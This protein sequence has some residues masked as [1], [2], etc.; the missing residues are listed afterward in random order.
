MK[1]LLRLL[2]FLLL[3]TFCGALVSACSGG[4]TAPTVPTS[5][6][7]TLQL[8]WVTQAQ[9]AG[10][11]VA[12][13]KGW[14]REEGIDLTIKPGGPDISPVDVVAG[15]A[16][17]FGT[18]LLADVIVAVQQGKP[19]ISI[20]QIQQTNGL[21]L[22]A[23]KVSGIQEPKDFI[24]KRVGV[25]LGNWEAQFNA[26]TAK[27]NLASTDYTLVAQGYSMDPFLKDELDVASAMIYNEYNTVLESGM[28]PEELNTID[29][30]DYGLDFPGDTLFTTR[31]TVE[32]DPELVTKM[33]RATLRGWQYAIEH[34]EEAAD[35]VLKYDKSG[36]QTREHQIAMMREISKLVLVTVRALGYT[37]RSDVQRTLDTLLL[38]KVLDQPVKPED[39]Y[40]N[41]FWEQAHQK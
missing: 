15:N 10:Y 16:A 22:L 13:D 3:M 26:L 2:V 33:L 9:F 30:A 39:V 12:L 40:T 25:W 34:P 29:Y 17:Q 6:P 1:H 38:Y 11:Y 14:Y 35:I 20:G 28:K 4:G 24:G 19:L 8:Q 41:A 18:S 7:V 23:K 31:Q 32:N 37:D 21:V 36:T 27:E 5:K